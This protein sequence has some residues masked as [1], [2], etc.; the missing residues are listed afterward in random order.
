MT[1]ITNIVKK[2]LKKHSFSKEDVPPEKELGLKTYITYQI[3]DSFLD[4]GDALYTP[5]KRGT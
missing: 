1:M 2:A 5:S 3:Q 4:K